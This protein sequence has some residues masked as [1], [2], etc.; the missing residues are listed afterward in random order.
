M[1]LGADRFATAWAAGQAAPL[2]AVVAA[3]LAG[4]GGPVS[5]EA[6]P[7]APAPVNGV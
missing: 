1:A 4:A 3:A 7:V 5:A 6:H 2:A